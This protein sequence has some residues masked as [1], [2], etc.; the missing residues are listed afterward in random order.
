MQTDSILTI[1]SKETGI[2]RNQLLITA[3]DKWPTLIK[4]NAYIPIR[5]IQHF[6]DQL[7]MEIVKRQIGWSK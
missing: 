4:I 1:M 3:V 7:M 6:E 5:M 2:D